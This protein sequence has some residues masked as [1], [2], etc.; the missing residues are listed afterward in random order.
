MKYFFAKSL[1]KNQIRL[2]RLYPTFRL[3]QTFRLSDS[4]ALVDNDGDVEDND[5]DVKEGDNGGNHA[6]DALLCGGKSKA[7]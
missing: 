5:G 4:T 3:F 6:V 1:I 7:M 2:F